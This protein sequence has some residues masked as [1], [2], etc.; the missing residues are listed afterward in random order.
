MPNKRCL[1]PT[2]STVYETSNKSDLTK[3]DKLIVSETPVSS[4]V[5]STEPDF[6]KA[7]I[8]ETRQYKSDLSKNN[9]QLVTSPINESISVPQ[10]ENNSR[11]E[12]RRS[13]RIQKRPKVSYREEDF[14][15]LHSHL[16]SISQINITTPNSFDEI[17]F[18]DDRIK[19]E[20]AI[21]DELNSLQT[22][23]TW[24]L[25]SKPNNRNIV[26]CKWV[27]TI[28]N[29]EHG[30]PWRCKA[31]LVAKGF[32]QEY[33]SDYNETFAPFARISTFRILLAIANQ[34]NL[35]VHHMDVKIAFLNG[36]LK[37]EIFMEFPEGAQITGNQV[38][39]LNKSIYG[40]KQ[41]AR[42]WFEIQKLIVAFIS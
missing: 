15:N 27:F 3:A 38:C 23:N 13:E 26:G 30:N 8:S 18:R 11:P 42:C 10:T 28:K 21:K 41:S 4:E 17:K 9:K 24:S 2:H 1:L 7:G 34:F 20:Q 40:L 5:N 33:L 32:S 22:N 39:I 16:L 29:D 6:S 36:V 31:R 12:L 25:V 19:W 37:E 14:D 35:P